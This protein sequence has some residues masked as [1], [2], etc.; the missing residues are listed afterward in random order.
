MDC[1]SCL[2]MGKGKHSYVLQL[3]F[4][5]LIQVPKAKL[6]VLSFP[7]TVHF[8]RIKNYFKFSFMWCAI[9]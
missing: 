4:S 9:K 8:G 5:Q 2:W 3:L 7:V 6:V 1:R